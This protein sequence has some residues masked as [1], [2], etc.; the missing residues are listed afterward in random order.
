MIPRCSK[1]G[2]SYQGTIQESQIEKLMIEA[3]MMTET[4]LISIP[5][6]GEDSIASADGV[7]NTRAAGFGRATGE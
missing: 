6:G 1:G 3:L 7:G 2:E 5:A 4:Q